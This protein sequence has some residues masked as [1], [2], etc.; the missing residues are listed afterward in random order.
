[1]KRILVTGSSGTIGTRLCE[2]FLENK[3][4]FIGVD[5][6]KNIWNKEIE[7][8]TIH[9]DLRNKNSVFK[10]LP[11]NIDL[12]VHLAANARVYNLVQNPNLALDNII[13]TFNILEF[14]H[15]NNIKNF[16]FA[17]SREVYGNSKKII[18]KEDDVNIEFI[19]SPY[20]ASK[21]SGELLTRS[22]QKCYGLNFIIIRFS[23]VYGMY[24]VSDRVVPLFIQL[25]KRNKNIIIYG[26]E[27]VLDF[28]Y[29]DDA[30]GGLLLAIKKFTKVKNNVFNIASG[31]GTK[32]IDVGKLIIKILNSKSKIIIKENRTGEVIKYIA[33]INKAKKLLNY[34]PKFFIKEGIIK[35]IEWY[36]NIFI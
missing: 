7:K 15:L 11:K 12:I 5:W 4:N 6:K 2:K 34:H 28:T 3:V 17:S 26:K 27:K 36:K 19:E 24:D 29:I 8:R 22:Y 21:L 31:R 35:S 32:I 23:N 30:V 33:N 18:H 9:I 16:I 14:A 10:K 25:A 1:M 20:S 13:T